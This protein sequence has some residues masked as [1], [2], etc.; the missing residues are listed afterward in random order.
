MSDW[1]H[2]RWGILLFA[3]GLAACGGADSPTAPTTVTG[4]TVTPTAGSPPPWSYGSGYTLKAVAL[5]GVVSEPTPDGPVPIANVTVYCDQCGASGHSWA[6]TDANGTYRFDGGLESGGGIWLVGNGGVR[7]QFSK[8]GYGD[9]EG[10][11]AAF[12]G[13][14]ALP[15]GGWRQTTISGD[16]RFDTQLAKQ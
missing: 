8:D 6:S 1:T 12:P 9:P 2:G 16:T 11:P 14:P 4:Q 13:V 15:S 5:F 7:L 3:L 10:L